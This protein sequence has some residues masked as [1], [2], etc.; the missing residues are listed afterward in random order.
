MT[1]SD[2]KIHCIGILKQKGPN[3]GCFVVFACKKYAQKMQAYA[4]LKY[5][6]QLLES[7]ISPDAPNQIKPKFEGVKL[8]IYCRVLLTF[9]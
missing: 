7:E 8:S 3:M 2:G 9:C 1:K 5:V 6:T 4:C